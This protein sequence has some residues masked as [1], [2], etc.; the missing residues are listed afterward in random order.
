MQR[1]AL[2]GVIQSAV[3]ASMR[4]VNAVPST[5]A[6]ASSTT[7]PLRMKSLHGC[8]PVNSAVSTRGCC[9][10]CCCRC[11]CLLLLSRT[12]PPE[13]LAEREDARHAAGHARGD[14]VGASSAGAQHAGA[15]H[16]RAGADCFGQLTWRLRD[17]AQAL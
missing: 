10:T 6:T 15:D 4:L 3:M 7:L 16:A 14:H 5:T 9:C 2:S 8:R 13:A 17:G 12:A 11:R 1:D